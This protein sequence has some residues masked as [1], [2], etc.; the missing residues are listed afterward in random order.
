ML[1][2]FLNS[3]SAVYEFPDLR[4]SG[5]TLEVLIFQGNTFEVIPSAYLRGLPHLRE[6]DLRTT[7]GLITMEYF[8]LASMPSL[9]IL[10]MIFHSSIDDTLD[11]HCSFSW[12][13]NIPPTLT[14]SPPSGQFCASPPERR[15]MTFANVNSVDFGYCPPGIG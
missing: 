9:T 10:R 15:S 3:F 8:P 2:Q 11:C 7:R 12:M 4:K 5:E 13:Q 14:F 1:F 6:L